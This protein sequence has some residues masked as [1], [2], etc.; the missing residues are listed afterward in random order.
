L[1]HGDTKGKSENL[2]LLICAKWKNDNLLLWYYQLKNMC[3]ELHSMVVFLT[4]KKRI[5]LNV[6]HF[7][8]LRNEAI[9]PY[10]VGFPT[11]PIAHTWWILRFKD[12]KYVTYNAKPF[13]SPH[14][15]SIKILYIESFNVMQ[16]N[17]VRI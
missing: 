7:E 2:K 4:W 13:H 9:W 5:G 3:N 16:H 11:N 8:A 14:P 1:Q 15:Q 17:I 10:W 12:S 6:P